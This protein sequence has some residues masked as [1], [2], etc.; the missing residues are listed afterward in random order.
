[1]FMICFVYVL[2]MVVERRK[3][4]SS[5]YSIEVVN[6]QDEQGHWVPM[7]KEKVFEFLAWRFTQ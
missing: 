2:Q 5:M 7:N 3:D 6:E 1:M 4:K